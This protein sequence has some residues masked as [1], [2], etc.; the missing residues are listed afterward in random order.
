M[1]ANAE[2]KTHAV[3]QKKPNAWGLYDMLGNVW[4]WCE[5]AFSPTAYRQPAFVDPVYR[6][7]AATER[8][9]RG[10]CWFLDV[11]SQRVALRGGN[12]PTFKSAYVGFRLVRE[13]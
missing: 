6:S 8:V 4:E 13:M 1:N 11:R 10:G 2:S 7:A 9:F 12:L 5:D 3:G